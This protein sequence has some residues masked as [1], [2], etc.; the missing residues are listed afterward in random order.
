MSHISHLFAELELRDITLAAPVSAR[1]PGRRDRALSRGGESQA[2]RNA[3]QASAAITGR[4][5]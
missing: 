5:S 4:G 2:W 1:R 3:A